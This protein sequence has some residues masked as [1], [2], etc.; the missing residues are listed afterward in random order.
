[1]ERDQ[2]LQEREKTHGDYRSTAE[3]AQRLKKIIADN[4][5]IT[6]PMFCN[7]HRESLDMICTKIARILS[8]NPAIKD[9]WDDIAGY[10]KLAAEATYI[11]D[12]IKYG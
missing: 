1:M 5:Q 12:Q 3:I 8:G 2:L 10:A 11:E 4:T 6:H 9:H 7:I